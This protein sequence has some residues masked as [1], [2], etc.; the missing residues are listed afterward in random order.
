MK[1][2]QVSGQAQKG[3]YRVFMDNFN[4]IYPQPIFPHFLRP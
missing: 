4:L 1:G 3:S 2:V